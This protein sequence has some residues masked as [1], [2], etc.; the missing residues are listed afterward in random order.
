MTLTYGELDNLSSLF[1]SSLNGNAQRAV[2]IH[3]SDAEVMIGGA[4]SDQNRRA[5]VME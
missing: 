5:G 1:N 4:N 3:E 2:E